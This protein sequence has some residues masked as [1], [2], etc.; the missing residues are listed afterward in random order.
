MENEIIPETNIDTLDD[1]DKTSKKSLDTHHKELLQK[2]IY[3]KIELIDIDGEKHMLCNISDQN[4]FEIYNQSGIKI[5]KGEIKEGL[6]HGFGIY[7]H[8]EFGSKKWQGN[9]VK[10]LRHGEGTKYRKDGT[11]K[12]E[13]SYMNDEKDGKG[14]SYFENGSIKFDGYWKQ[15]KKN[16][17]GIR[18]RKN[19][20]KGFQGP[21]VD[22]KQHGIG[23]RYDING[24]KIYQGYFDNG[25]STGTGKMFR[26]CHGQSQ[27]EGL[28]NCDDMTISIH[29]YHYN[30]M[31]TISKCFQQSNKHTS[32]AKNFGV[33]KR[34]DGSISEV[35]NDEKWIMTPEEKN[36]RLTWHEEHIDPDYE[37]SLMYNPTLNFINL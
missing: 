9:F 32:L 4:I 7:Y 26:V 29:K 12:F 17:T 6:K 8:N 11:T 5:Y 13:G 30:G 1:S 14:I 33:I 2:G 18:Y 28:K 34:P 10:D 35:H 25:V 3:D 16:G 19:G 37:L 24:S 27:L 21:Y 23:I 31:L 22:G 36:R 20:T 15:D